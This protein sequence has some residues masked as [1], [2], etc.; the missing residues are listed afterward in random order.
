MTVQSS[1]RPSSIIT[2]TMSKSV[3]S[4]RGQPINISDFEAYAR[5]NLQKQVYDYYRSGANDEVTLGENVAAY[6]RLIIRPRFLVDVSKLDGQQMRRQQ[7]CN[8][9]SC[10]RLTFVR[11]LLFS[12]HHH[13]R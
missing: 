5:T 6:N 8:I 4:T 7:Q 13:P 3:T 11:F 10:T 12:Q 1:L 2:S 9:E